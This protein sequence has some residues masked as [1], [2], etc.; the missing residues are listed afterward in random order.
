MSGPR[1]DESST[2]EER[3]RNSTYPSPPTEGSVS[4]DVELAT[5]SCRKFSAG[6]QDC[7]SV[8]PITLTLC[9]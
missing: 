2:V 8:L 9:S 7:L 4:V 1:I 6:V 5:L 3:A